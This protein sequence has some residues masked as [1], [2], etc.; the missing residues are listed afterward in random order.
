[1]FV[2]AV[3]LLAL[4]FLA[5]EHTHR[6]KSGESVI[7]WFNTIGPKDNRQETYPFLNLPFCIG[8]GNLDHYHETI[9]EAFLGLEL[10]QSGMDILFNISSASKTLCTTVLTAADNLQF[11]HAVFNEYVFNL[12]VD[13]FPLWGSVGFMASNG[14]VAIFTHRHYQFN[15]NQDSIVYIEYF[16]SSNLVISPGND[17]MM[18]NWTYSVSFT[19]TNDTFDSRYF[20]KLF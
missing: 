4:G 9:G 17:V 5:D 1:M 14:T 2:L 12:Y 8:K 15:I 19:S 11:H 16:N 20:F 13:D 7:V 10:V 3:A 6:Y 18:I